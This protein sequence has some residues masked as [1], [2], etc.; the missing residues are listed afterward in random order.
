[1]NKW[2]SKIR[3]NSRAIVSTSIWCRWGDYQAPQGDVQNETDPIH[4][5][6]DVPQVCGSYV[7]ARAFQVMLLN[8]FKMLKGR[9]MSAFAELE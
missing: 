9:D 8:R 3:T 7:V 1:M 2:G 4:S 5:E 6:T